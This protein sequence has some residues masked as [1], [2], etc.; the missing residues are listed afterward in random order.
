MRSIK[1]KGVRRS[2]GDLGVEINAV[3]NFRLGSESGT[4]T[5]NA[6]NDI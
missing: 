2:I 4:S 5:V 6:M 1:I 3:S